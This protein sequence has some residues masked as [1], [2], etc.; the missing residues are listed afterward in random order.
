[1]FCFG[2]ALVE[3][4]T[5]KKLISYHKF[6]HKGI[7]HDIAT[8]CITLLE[9]APLLNSLRDSGWSD[10]GTA[11]L[12]LVRCCLNEN[13]IERPKMEEVVSEL[14]RI[15]DALRSRASEV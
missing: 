1:M 5:G 4:L 7:H 9:E 3:L 13:T 11:I 15:R 14:N 6:Q 10:Q 12:E 8:Q 2:V